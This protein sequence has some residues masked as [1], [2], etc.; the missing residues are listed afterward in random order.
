[1]LV[2]CGVLILYS[3]HVVCVLSRNPEAL[4]PC[5]FLLISI[6]EEPSPLPSSPAKSLPRG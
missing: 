3:K 6:R 2:R 4:K 1:M 5:S